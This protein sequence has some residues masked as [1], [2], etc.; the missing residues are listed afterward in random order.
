MYI[1][2]MNST[3]QGNR[4]QQQV[5]QEKHICTGKALHLV[6]SEQGSE[7]ILSCLHLYTVSRL[8]MSVLG[9]QVNTRTSC[10]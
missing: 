7:P 9:N 4:N 3:V 2:E 1:I 8:Q 5:H 6:L 10:R